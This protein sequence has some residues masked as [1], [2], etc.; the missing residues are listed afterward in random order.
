MRD[1]NKYKIRNKIWIEAAMFYSE[2]YQSIKKSSSAINTLLRCLQKRKWGRAKFHG[3]KQNVYYDEGFIFPYTEAKALNISGT[4]QHWENLRKLVEVGFLD[5]VHQGGWYQ[6]NEREKDYSVYKLSDRWRKYNTPEFIIIEKPKAL[7]DSFHIQ[8]NI[9]KKKLKVTSL[10][11]S[12][13]LRQSEGDKAKSTKYR[14]RQ[15][16]GDKTA[17][18]NRQ[19]LAIT[20]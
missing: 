1:D 7:P 4:T 6:K 12:G 9:T 3:K 8:K 2:A 13:Q 20:A 10:E 16:E 15:S 11:R 17:I 19:S 18:K 14:L 5:V